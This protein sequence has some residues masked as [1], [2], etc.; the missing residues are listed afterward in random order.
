M[1]RLILHI[2]ICLALVAVTN[3]VYRDIGWD[4]SV[5]ALG[6]LIGYAM[7]FVNRKGEDQ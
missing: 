6:V 4:T 5:I 1:I 2:S 3:F 7:S